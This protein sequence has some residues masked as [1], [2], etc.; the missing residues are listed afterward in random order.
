MNPIT[1][2]LWFDSQ[3]EEAAEFY[4]SIFPNSSIGAI[5][6]HGEAGKELHGKPVGSVMTVAFEINGQSFTALNGG[7]MFRFSEAVSFQVNCETQAELDH[8]WNNLSKGGDENAQ[9]CGWLKDKF[10]VSWQIV[11]NILQELLKDNDP[12]KS[13]RMMSALLQMKKLDIQALKQAYAGE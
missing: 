13:Q 10:G 2:C 4:T 7:P 3:A 6:R 9:Q 11:P 8:Y 1:P 5:T 12:V